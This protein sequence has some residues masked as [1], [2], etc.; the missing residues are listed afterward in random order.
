M[1]RAL[2]LAVLLTLVL[3]ACSEATVNPTPETVDPATIPDPT[4]TPA[5]TPTDK[6]PVILTI[7][8]ASLPETT[9]PYSGPATAAK[10]RLTDLLFPPALNEIDGELIPLL[11]ER[12]PS[13]DNGDLRLE[14]V[15]IR[16]GQMVI[17]TQGQLV[18]AGE[19]V[20]LWPSGCREEA[21]VI[22][23]NGLDPLE[24]DQMVVDY[25]LR[26]GL[27]WSDGTP[28]TPA[29]AVFS[30]HLA[31]DPSGTAFGWAETYTQTFSAWDAHT[32]TW[33]G[34]PGFASE[35]IE[36]FFWAPLPAH[37]FAENAE[38]AAIAADPLWRADM[39]GYGPFALAE[40]G[41]E[42]L[43]LTRNPHTPATEA[44]FPGVDQVILRRVEG[45]AGA[46]WDALQARTCDVLDA[47]F[48]LAERP[49]LLD[50]IRNSDSYELWIEP[51]STSTQL[52]FGIRPA[53]YDALANPV[54][55]QRKDFFADPRT[56]QALAQCIDTAALAEQTGTQP[57]I[58]AG[59]SYDP[60]AGVAL[61]EQTGWHDHD[62]DPST[63][64]QAQDALGVFNLTP[65]TLTLLAGP[66]PFHQDLA[67]GIAA[68]LT[69]CGVGVTV[70]TL[71]IEELYAPGPEGPLFGRG[72]DLALI[73]WQPSP[74]P[75]CA[76]YTS[77]VVPHAANSWIGTNI[78]GFSDPD[79]DAACITALLA[80]PAEA[81]ARQAAAD[82]AY[83]EHLPALPLVQPVQ[84]EVWFEGEK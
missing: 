82:D 68:L 37:R 63:P 42:E 57:A 50:A 21:C 47:S 13:Q 44:A 8:T 74:A 31:S 62:G 81:A 79:Y 22:T 23:W 6:T 32:L 4:A 70:E 45:G 2:M 78:A 16:R 34:Y 33:R 12:I 14:A 39:P 58:L 66:T 1:K 69:A 49:D 59:L 38:G 48:N 75:G 46:A 7:C 20:R 65:L 72:F 26:D 5:P 83:L 80:P 35:H 25:T 24:M 15:S 67:A 9:F 17:D 56:R 76:L 71:P 11:L 55:A 27:T 29:D 61:L 40:W 52:V 64:R 51:D 36:Q 41:V 77:P 60:V 3:T 73:A 18:M 28:V 84:V 10:R 53:E 30:Y 19:G 54:F 43:R